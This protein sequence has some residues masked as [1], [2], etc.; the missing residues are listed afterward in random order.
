MIRNTIY[1]LATTLLLLT[2][3]AIDSWGQTYYVF[4]YNGHYVA[5]NGYTTDGSEICVED[6]FSIEKCLWEHTSGGGSNGNQEYL[7]TYGANYWLY[8][9]S[10]TTDPD[11]YTYTLALK[12]TAPQGG[13]KQDGWNTANTTDGIR[14]YLRISSGSGYPAHFVC[15]NDNETPCWELVTTAVNK[16]ALGT[17]LTKTETS[18]KN[19]SSAIGGGSDVISVKG[20]YSYNVDATTVNSLSYV[21]FTDAGTT[22]YWYDDSEHDTAPVDW[23]N[24]EVASLTKTWSI[25]EGGEYASINA[26]NGELTVT[27]LP[28]SGSATVTIR[29]VI[30]DNASHSLTVVDT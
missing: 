12:S 24:V 5:H 20:T 8:Y 10:N 4:K 14:R 21:S 26:A 11:N 7:K 9:L 16:K 25:V 2:T 17:A 6:N 27:D 28:T 29:C 30:A 18:Y 3:W 15:Y 19:V 23:G 13:D 1:K 22:R